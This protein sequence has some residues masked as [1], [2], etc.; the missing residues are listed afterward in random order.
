MSR[1]RRPSDTRPRP[2]IDVDVA[3]RGDDYVVT[4]DLP[5]IRKQ[6]VDV[7]VKKSRVQILVDPE[8]ES[9]TGGA[10]ARRA[11]EH[12]PIT[13]IVRLPERVDE[14]RTDAEYLNGQLR[15]TLRKRQRRR[16]VEV[17]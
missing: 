11:R 4:A 5:G 1:K 9:E 10:F 16:S 8:G 2:T 6:D 17:E 15:I 13:R 14:K 12:G 3:D 7:R